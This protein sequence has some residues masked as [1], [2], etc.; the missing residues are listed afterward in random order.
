MD[1]KTLVAIAGA[2][3]L[4]SCHKEPTIATQH[5]SRTIELDQSEQTRLQLRMGVGNLKVSGGS[6]HLA[7][8]DFTYNVAAWKPEV[9][10]HSTGTRSDLSISQRENVNSSGETENRWDIRLNDKVPMDISVHFGVGEAVM[11]LGSLNL[12][13]VNLA[14]GVGEVRMDLRGNPTKSYDVH[15]QGGVGEATVYLPKNVGIIATASGAVGDVKVDGLLE[16]DGRY[17]NAG[18]EN[19]PVTIRV[20]VKGGVGDIHLIAE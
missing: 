20:D 12:R 16:R 7:D 5:E 10:Y 18:Q 14:V 8:A 1:A 19:S 15:I 6:Q 9:E 2:V 11:N 4:A 17:I 3:L 13:D